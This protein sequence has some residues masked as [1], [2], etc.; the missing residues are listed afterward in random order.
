MI[1]TEF[2][3]EKYANGL[4]EEGR[5]E[6]RAEGLTEGLLSLVNDGLLSASIAASRCDKTESEFEELLNEYRKRLST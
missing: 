6:G 4:R 1:I 2:D 5:E 3:E